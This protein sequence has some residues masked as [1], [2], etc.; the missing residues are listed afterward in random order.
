MYGLPFVAVWDTCYMLAG[1]TQM[2][3]PLPCA[4]PVSKLA[5]ADFHFGA[6]VA[7][8]EMLEDECTLF[9]DVQSDTSPIQDFNHL[10]LLLHD[11]K[12]GKLVYIWQLAGFQSRLNANHDPMTEE[13]WTMSVDNPRPYNPVWTDM[14]RTDALQV[15]LLNQFNNLSP[16]VSSTGVPIANANAEMKRHWQWQHDIR[17][18]G[19]EQGPGNKEPGR[20]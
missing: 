14:S 18:S 12:A 20:I 6:V 1:Q 15:H 19:R 13:T 10:V 17:D 2:W 4:K 7:S 9:V 3:G 8:P 11:D 16:T 5:V